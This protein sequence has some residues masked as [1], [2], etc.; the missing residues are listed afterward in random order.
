VRVPG[1]HSV[2]WDALPQTAKAVAA[3]LSG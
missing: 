2:L 3:H 1:S